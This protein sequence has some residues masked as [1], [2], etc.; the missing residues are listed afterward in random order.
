MTLKK[1]LI[2]AFVLITSVSLAQKKQQEEKEVNDILK[3]Y[4][5]TKCHTKSMRL[6][7]PSFNA[8]AKREYSREQLVELI[9]HPEPSNWPGYATMPTIDTLRRADMEK[10][11]DWIATLRKE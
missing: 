5:C 7:G 2:P 3:K 8:V 1:T 11:A 10:V 9:L 6:V 4:T